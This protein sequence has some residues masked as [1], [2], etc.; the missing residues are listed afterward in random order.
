MN[1]Y[2]F[3]SNSFCLESRWR[4]G[5]HIALLVAVTTALTMLSFCDYVSFS[6][7]IQPRLNIFSSHIDYGRYLSA[8]HVSPDLD[9]VFT[10]YWV[11]NFASNF[12]EY[13]SFS[14]S[15][16]CYDRDRMVVGFTTTCAYPGL[17]NSYQLP[18]VL[19]Y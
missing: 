9:F 14:I 4:W 17:Y 2:W 6:I 8:G 3:D 12:H 19:G 11:L 1:I 16:R 5:I 15:I 13:I 10:V 18:L 7:T